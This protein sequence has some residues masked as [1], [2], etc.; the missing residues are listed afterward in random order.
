MNDAAICVIAK[1]RRRR[2]VLPV[3]RRLVF[4]R[5]IPS[6]PPDEGRRGTLCLLI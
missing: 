5:L 1:M 3:M 6:D 2:L 4:V